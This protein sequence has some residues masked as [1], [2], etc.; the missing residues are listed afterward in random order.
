MTHVIENLNGEE[1]VKTCYKKKLRKK[2]QTE[3]RVKKVIKRK[4]NKL[5]V[6][7]KDYNN[8][9]NIWIDKKDIAIYMSCFP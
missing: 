8:Y 6:K 7:W 1:I 2:N 3:F 5:Y 4:G 9:V